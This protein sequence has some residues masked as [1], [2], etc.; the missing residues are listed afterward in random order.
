MRQQVEVKSV[1]PD[2]YASVAA[3]RRS[4][5]SG[6]C[7]QCSG[8]GAVV[9]EVQVLARNPIGA[10][11]GDQV[12]VQTENK[13]VF[14]AMLVVYLLPLVLLLAGYLAGS[15]AGVPAGL[16][17]LAGFGL[18]VLLMLWYNRHVA[19]RGQVQFTI[20]AFAP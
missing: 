12:I 20:T 13:T 7:H 18:G 11:P 16:G 8:C 1:T 19:R 4:A 3:L 10:K 9:Q 2:G 14:R 5:F 6:D 15:A 17:A